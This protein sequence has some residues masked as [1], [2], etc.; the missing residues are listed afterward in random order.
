MEMLPIKALERK[1]SAVKYC[2]CS[3]NGSSES[4]ARVERSLC[5]TETHHFPVSRTQTAAYTCGKS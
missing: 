1:L 5:R 3:I 4:L 2:K